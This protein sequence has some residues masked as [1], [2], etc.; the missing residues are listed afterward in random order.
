[1]QACSRMGLVC[2]PLYESLGENAIEYIIDHSEASFI[3]VAAAK[4]PAFSKALPK[5]NAVLK[6]VVYWGK[7][8]SQEALAAIQSTGALP[9][10]PLTASH[11]SR[12][13]SSHQLYR[14]LL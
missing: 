4:L 2:V 1:M 11:S 6:G 7:D 12:N 13:N 3:V 8:A 9:L 14:T 10:S 5:I